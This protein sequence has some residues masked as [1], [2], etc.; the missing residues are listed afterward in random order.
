MGTTCNVS[1]QS[2][3]TPCDADERYEYSGETHTGCDTINIDVLKL[4]L[5]LTHQAWKERETWTVYSF[6][7]GNIQCCFGV[8]RVKNDVRRWI[9]NSQ[10]YFLKTLHM[11][12]HPMRGGIY[13]WSLRLILIS[14]TWRP[15][16][17]SVANDPPGISGGVYKIF[18][19]FY[20]PKCEIEPMLTR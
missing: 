5:Y 2:I 1:Y 15:R 14:S 17:G 10:K 12:R 18:D 16:I 6:L 20:E 3:D 19:I 7:E 8:E 11:W 4:Y 9:T 13:M